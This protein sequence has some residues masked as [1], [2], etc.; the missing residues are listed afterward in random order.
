[1]LGALMQHPF[2]IRNVCNYC[3]CLLADGIES[4]KNLNN[5]YVYSCYELVMCVYVYTVIMQHNI[6]NNLYTCVITNSSLK[7]F[8]LLLSSWQE[9]KVKYLVYHHLL[10]QVQML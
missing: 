5:M 9:Q 8:F 1:M 4:V 3:S 6:Y 7:V 2:F 10:V